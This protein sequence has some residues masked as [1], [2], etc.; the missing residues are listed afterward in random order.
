VVVT[1]DATMN[2]ATVLTYAQAAEVDQAMLAAR[3]NEHPVGFECLGL[4]RPRHQ[5][6][7]G[8]RPANSAPSPDTSIA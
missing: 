8:A 6:K 5:G 4:A 2:T 7:P 3:P 1:L